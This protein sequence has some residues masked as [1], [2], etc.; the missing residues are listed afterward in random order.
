MR[1]FFILSNQRKEESYRVA[2]QLEEEIR[3]QCG[4]AKVCIADEKNRDVDFTKDLLIPEGSECVIVIGGDGTVLS[5]AKAAMNEQVPLLGVNLGNLGY[6]TEVEIASIP[7]AVERLLADDYIIENRMMLEGEIHGRCISALNDIVLSRKGD[8]QV[9]GYRIYVNGLLLN[10]FFADG[11]IL[12]T[13]TGST[14]YNLSAGGSIVEPSAQLIV[15]TQVCPHTLNARSIILSPEDR[16]EVEILPP[17]GEKCVSV[18]AYFDGGN[19]V[20]IAPGERICI[21][22]S[23]HKTKMIKL[24]DVSFLKVL[25][26]KIGE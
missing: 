11:V 22:R 23:S 18:G 17:K 14:G 8:L 10:D 2:L 13:P 5:V 9:V 15:L 4:D 20:D 7:R 1:S 3:R 19:G 25:H 6:L 16:I 24:S 26:Q 21:R 12:S